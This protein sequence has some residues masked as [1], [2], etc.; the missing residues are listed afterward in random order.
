[1]RILLK[2]YSL[3]TI[4]SDMNSA[5][6]AVLL[7]ASIVATTLSFSGSAVLSKIPGFDYVIIGTV[8]S[9]LLHRLTVL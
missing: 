8:L 9:F 4:I 6:A 1:M 7:E 5:K 3:L 2:Q